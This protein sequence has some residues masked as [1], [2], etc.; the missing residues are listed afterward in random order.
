MHGAAG[1]QVRVS[2]TITWKGGVIKDYADGTVR[3]YTGTYTVS[4][5][6]WTIETVP[7]QMT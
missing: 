6:S 1:L 2:V 5:T 3:T 4:E 7:S